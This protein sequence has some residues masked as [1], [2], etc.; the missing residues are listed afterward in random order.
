V[1]NGIPVLALYMLARR[2]EGFGFS[3]DLK[4][5]TKPELREITH[6]AWYHSLLTV[7]MVVMENLELIMLPTLDIT[8]MV[9]V[10]IYSNSIYITTVARIPARAMATATFPILTKAY[11]AG[12]HQHVADLFHRSGLN[13]MLASTLMFLLIGLNMHNV[14]ALFPEKYAP[15]TSLVLILLIGRFVD[16]STGLNNELMSISTLYK[17]NFRITAL[18]VVVMAAVNYYLIPRYGVYGAAWGTTISVSSFNLLKM[19]VV[20]HKLKLQPFSSRT[21]LVII[22]G[23][24]AALA[25][26]F[27]P[28][29]HDPYSDTAVRSIVICIAYGLMLLWL[30]PSADLQTYISSVRSNKRLF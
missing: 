6:F 16:I 12:D 22:C 5:F 11:E 7:S 2:T 9:A 10:A 17:F 20:W 25:G 4:A 15:M 18:M 14:V 27:L 24:V 30:K 23:G 28:Y 3:I 26:Y 19:A 13:I 21:L 1:A 8:G 29:V